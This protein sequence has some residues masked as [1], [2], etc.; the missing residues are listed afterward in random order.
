MYSVNNEIRVKK[1]PS[2]L[3]KTIDNSKGLVYSILNFYRRIYNYLWSFLGYRAKNITPTYESGNLILDN[4]KGNFYM[5]YVELLDLK[6]SMY[7]YLP[8]N[9]IRN[10]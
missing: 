10:R 8:S 1:F 6:V 5:I 7:F 3:Y 4:T 2:V 9:V